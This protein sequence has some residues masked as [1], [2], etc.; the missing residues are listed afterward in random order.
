MRFTAASLIAALAVG[1]LTACA[2]PL[3]A[4]TSNS[5]DPAVL[6]KAAPLTQDADVPDLDDI[7]VM[8]VDSGM[9]K[10]LDEHVKRSRGTTL[11]LHELLYA[12]ITKG[13]F[14]LEYDEITRT[15]QQTFHARRGNCLSFTI[16]FVSMARAV[17]V[18]ATFQE[19]DIP[20]SWSR[21]GDA[22]M[23][24]RHV[25]VVV[26]LI[27]GDVR[28]VDFNVDDFHSSYDRKRIS[29]ERALAHYYSNIGVEHLQENN[30]LEALR[31]FR[32]AIATDDQFA[33]AW[34]N[35]GALYS[36]SG[37]FEYA[38][39]A[40]IQA[41]R[42]NPKELVAMSNLGQ[43]YDY[44]GKADL[45]DWYNKRSNQHR[46]R[47]PYYQYYL[48]HK[49]FLAND[50]ETAIKHLKY[51]IRMRKNEDT[52]YFLMGLSY[53][54]KGDELTAHRWLKKAQQ[55]TADDG[56]KR[57]YHNKLERLLGTH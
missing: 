13:S 52:F 26:D 47:N 31:F 38:E 8:A 7:D 3:I 15:A 17:G 22:Y 48:A 56:L 54:E 4:P 10:F 33:P 45:A 36:Q 50:Y 11:K 23:L 24:S 46:M 51:A 16:M 39:A 12:I 5:L 30:L 37:N 42:V 53:L 27:G 29:D 32:K 21:E 20:P 14:G 49:A 18:N 1:F 19:I 55:V 6:L 2:A 57:N 25:N 44:Q 34:S 28:E 40:Y 43:L 41:L 9:R 35:L